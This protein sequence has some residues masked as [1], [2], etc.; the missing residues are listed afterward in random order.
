MKILKPFLLACAFTTLASAAQ[1]VYYIKATGEVGKELSQLAKDYAKEKGA[2]VEVFV[3][4]DPRRYKDTRL[5]KIGV[6]QRG[7]YSQSLGKELYIKECASCHGEN[8]DK[9]PNG[10]TPL[11]KLSAKDISDSIVSYRNDPEFGKHM[12]SVM[13]IQAKRVSSA[14]MGAIIAYLKG[15]D[16]LIDQ[17]EPNTPVSTQ[18][19]QGSYLR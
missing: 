11:T 13:Q 7:R 6:N 4:E 12:R 8:A 19:K 1:Q 15:S 16:A 2:N 5:L 17:L 10:A 18:T 14:D 3:D 9:R